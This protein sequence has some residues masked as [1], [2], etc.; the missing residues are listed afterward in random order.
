TLIRTITLASV[1][2]LALLCGTLQVWGDLVIDTFDTE[3]AA[4][5][6][7]AT[8]GTS[9][10]LSFD[11][12]NAS[13]GAVGSGSLRVSADYFTA[14]DNGWEQMIVTRTIDPPVVGSRYLSVHARAQLR[15]TGCGRGN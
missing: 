10:V 7:A 11:P 5:A 3:A 1:T 6:V 4:G 15:S 8:W 13:G 12:Q 9:P 2:S 14:E